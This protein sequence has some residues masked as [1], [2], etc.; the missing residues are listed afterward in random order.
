MTGGGGLISTPSL[1]LTITPPGGTA[2]NYTGSLAWSGTSQQ[3][4]INQSFGRQG[5]TATIVLADDWSQNSSGRPSFHIP[6]LS[7][8][9]LYDNIA[10]TSLFAGVVTDPVLQP[11][12]AQY[13]EWA[14]ACTDYTFYADNAIVHGTYYGW[15][16]DAILVD[17]TAQ[18]ACGIS[19]ATIR[20]GG[21]V[22]PGPQLASFVLNYTTLS[23]AW[24][25]LAQLAG[26]VT[27]YGWYVDQNRNLHFYDSSTAQASG[28]TL[29]TNPTQG[30]VTNEGHILLDGNFSYEWDGTS[31]RN[32]ILVQ[33]ANQ[34]IT[35]GAVGT[36]AP[37]NTWLGDGATISWP[38]RYTVT[39]SPQLH[40]NGV[41]TSV[42][43][44]NAGASASGQWVVQQNSIGQWF[45]TAATAPAAGVK[46]QIWYDY[47]IPVVA[48]ANDYASQAQYT[49]PNSGVFQEYISDTSLTTAPMALARA[50][51]QRT[52]YA[53]AAERTTF[54][55][56]P[57]WLGWVRA[58]QTCTI[59]NGLVPDSQRGYAWG[60]ND[61]FIVTGNSV[62]FG[63]G[64]YRQCQM[65]AVRL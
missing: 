16:V 36:T 42:T 23:T 55:T 27:P 20:S 4:T 25:R 34:T 59:V 60:V 8:V 50:Q 30:G 13:N 47:Q 7:Q 35:H 43:V 58:G 11:T 18:A 21:F 45:L 57:D 22:A 32:R 41:A 15:T 63:E 65:T 56:S 10:A 14:L 28:V 40:V 5:D 64:G 62:T 17:L 53:F 51:R 33:G 44:A 6:V 2:T 29:T 24:R 31:I 3:I 46:L 12:A 54:T 9:S 1:T 48:R 52:E 19:A 39:G 37:T 49:G 61:T 26:Q 38:L